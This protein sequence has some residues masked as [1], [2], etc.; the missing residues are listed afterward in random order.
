MKNL[1]P[2]ISVSILDEAAGIVN[3]GER[4]DAY[5]HPGENFT[6]IAQMWSTY[7][8]LRISAH[9]VCMLMILLKVTRAMKEYHRD[10]AVDIAGYARCDDRIDQWGSR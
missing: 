1:D 9:D 3:G 7:L 6:R 4:E 2:G 8:G 5:G 10:T